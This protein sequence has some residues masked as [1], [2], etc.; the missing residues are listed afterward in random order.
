[1]A[2]FAYCEGQCSRLLV[3]LTT[4][5]AAVGT[6]TVIKSDSFFQPALPV[7][8]IKLLAL[9]L[10]LFAVV[11]AWGH[12]LL[13]L[14][15]GGHI[16]LPKGRETTRDLAAHDIASREQLIINYYH[17]AIEELT[18]VIHE[19]NKYIIIAYEELTMSAWFFGIVSAVAI[20]TEIL[21]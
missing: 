11:C 13:A 21:S 6:V 10:A 17:Q 7:E 2:R 12:A 5:L 4:I 19:K 9:L 15:I 18:E 16:E 8:W 1:M 3:F 20:G 14:K